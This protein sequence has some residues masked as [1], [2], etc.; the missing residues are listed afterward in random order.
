[1]VQMAQPGSWEGWDRLSVGL[2][3]FRLVEEAAAPAA[4]AVP[5]WAEWRAWYWGRSG[6]DGR[7]RRQRWGRHHVVPFMMSV[8]GG[9]GSSGERWTFGH[10]WERGGLFSGGTA[11]GILN[12]GEE[13]QTALRGA[14]GRRRGGDSAGCYSH[15][16]RRWCQWWRQR[17]YGRE[18]A[19]VAAGHPVAFVPERG[20][21]DRS[22]ISSGNGGAGGKAETEQLA[23]R[24]PRWNWRRKR[25]EASAGGSGGS[26]AR[27]GD[28]GAGRRRQWW[29]KA[30]SVYGKGA[31]PQTNN[32]M[33]NGAGGVGGAGG[34]SSRSG[35]GVWPSMAIRL[36]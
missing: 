15:G 14:G 23:G 22:T 16:G 21:T 19:A 28:S 10:K 33:T 30:F 5:K 31:T 36:E 25:G 18:K 3:V 35:S 1:M 27:G 20:H 17:G 8:A 26:G 2:A 6:R 9:N 24:W 29:C 11:T 12:S 7:S 13:G 32:T 34:T 4:L